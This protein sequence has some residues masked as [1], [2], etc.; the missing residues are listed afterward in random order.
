MRT[1]TK[2]CPLLTNEKIN[3]TVQSL[4]VQRYPV[5]LFVS[6]R[7]ISFI[8]QRVFSIASTHRK[9]KSVEKPPLRGGDDVYPFVCDTV[10]GDVLT[11]ATHDSRRGSRTRRWC[12]TLVCY[13]ILHV[14]EQPAK[15]ARMPE[16]IGHCNQPLHSTGLTV[17]AIISIGY[18][19]MNERN[20]LAKIVAKFLNQ[21]STGKLS[22]AV[23]C[24]AKFIIVLLVLSCPKSVFLLQARLLQRCVFI[25]IWNLI[26]RTLWSLFW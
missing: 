18:R 17:L 8:A 20:R 6:S 12:V 5:L 16:R 2:I 10:R 1:L 9:T 11:C 15:I 25:Q 14:H 21:R 4:G 7:R 24:H 3:R 26:C 19:E 22:Y 13:A 23:L